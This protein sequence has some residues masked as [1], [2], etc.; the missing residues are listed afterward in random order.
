[1]HSPRLLQS[2]EEQGLSHPRRLLFFL[3]GRFKL[4]R[5]LIS[6]RF[7]LNPGSHKHVKL[8]TSPAHIPRPRHS[9]SLLQRVFSHRLKNMRVIKPPTKVASLPV[10]SASQKQIGCFL[11]PIHE[12]LLLQSSSRVHGERG[13][14][15]Y[16]KV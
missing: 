14:V 9:T 2:I 8:S 6:Q 16:K 15:I 12:P 10:N 7:P 4:I 13:N 11:S 5:E 1:M 3:L